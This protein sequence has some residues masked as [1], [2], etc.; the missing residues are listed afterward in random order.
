MPGVEHRL[1]VVD[2]ALPRDFT[3]ER[4][5]SLLIGGDNSSWEFSGFDRALNF[6]GA[7]VWSYDFV[8]FATSAFNTLYVA[9]LERFEPSLL[10]VL[11]NRAVCVGH[12]DCYNEPVEVRGYHAQHWIRSC[13]F[14]FRRPKQKLWVVSCPS[15]MDR[16][17]SAAVQTRRSVPTRQ[18]ARAIGNI[19]RS[20]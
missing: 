8:H 3:D 15:R 9:Y 5:G 11:A 16:R 2:N 19:L 13:F 10:E 12:I 17:F 20:G 4:A 18:S 14:I 6:L 7:D 1:I